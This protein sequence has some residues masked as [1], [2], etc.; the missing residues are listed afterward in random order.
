[1]RT[2]LANPNP[3]PN[4]NPDPNPNPTLGYEVRTY[5]KLDVGGTCSDSVPCDPAH[6]ESGWN[7]FHVNPKEHWCTEGV[8]RE[9]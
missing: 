4:P 2:W 5:G 6:N 8:D 3:N 9:G 1:M 7:G